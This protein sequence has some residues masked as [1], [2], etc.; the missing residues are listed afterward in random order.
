MPAQVKTTGS[1][2]EAVREFFAAEARNAEKLQRFALGLSEEDELPVYD[3]NDPKNRY[4]KAMYP[5]DGGEPIVVKSTKEEHEQ[6]ALGFF[7]T[8]TE[9]AAAAQAYEQAQYDQQNEAFDVPAKRSHS[10]KR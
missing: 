1:T 5:A 3:P 8:P 2:R 6:E 9:A 10:R 4:P 7:A